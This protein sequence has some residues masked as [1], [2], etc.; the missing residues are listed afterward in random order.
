MSR[1]LCDA[2][3]TYNKT[4]QVLLFSPLIHFIKRKKCER[5][6]ELESKNMRKSMQK[7][8]R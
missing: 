2:Y 8:S 6:L 1:Q 5:S 7:S 4:V 3:N